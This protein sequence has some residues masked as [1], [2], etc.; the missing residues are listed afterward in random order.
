[1]RSDEQGLLTTEYTD[2]EVSPATTASVAL[3]RDS[4]LTMEVDSDGDGQTDETFMPA[5]AEMDS[6]ADG[7]PEIYIGSSD[8]WI[9]RFPTEDATGGRPPEWNQIFHDARNTN[10]VPFACPADLDGDRFVGISDLLAL[11]AAWGPC[12]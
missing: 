12:R 6:D 10:S 5:V 8:G 11:L 1:M 2:V 7:T 9:Y 3:S 4:G